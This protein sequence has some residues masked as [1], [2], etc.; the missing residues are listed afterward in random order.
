MLC[1]SLRWRGD[2][3]VA[4]PGTIADFRRGRATA[5]PLVHPWANRL[6]RRSYRA[7]GRRVDLRGVT[8][9]TDGAG[10]PIHGNVFGVP[11]DVV[12][13]DAARVVARLDYGA[14]R[15]LMRA[16]PFPHLV[17]VDARLHAQRGLTI[18]TEVRPTGRL[19]VPVSFG[20]HP[21]LRLPGPRR[22]D[23]K[24]YLPTREHLEL[25]ERL[26]PTGRSV[27]EPAERARVGRRTFDDH[28][29]L[30]RDRTFVLAAHGRSL[31]LR[32]G[33]AYPFAQL[34]A[35]AG[36]EYVAIEPMTAP[37]DA[38]GRGVAPVVHAGGRF[39]ATFSLAVH[40]GPQP[41]GQLCPDSAHNRPNA[42]GRAVRAN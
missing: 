14:H 11:F 9:P 27:R 13:V 10:L 18:T 25:D 37:I 26:V 16:F 29:A 36:R 6:A 5:V 38:L 21:Y 17:T 20:W 42:S 19:A 35:P 1:T 22:A 32:F 2:E 24:L 40:A 33:R 12:H 34:F 28:Y 3:Y 31:S 8:L 41:F 4:R 7:A 15:A 39:R 23:W 30:G